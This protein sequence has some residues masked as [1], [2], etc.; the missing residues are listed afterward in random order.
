HAEHYIA[1]WA[2]GSTALSRHNLSYGPYQL[3]LT[4]TLGCQTVYPISLGAHDC[5]RYFDIPNVFTPNGDG[6][7]D[8]LQVRTYCIDRFELQIF[9]RW[10][11]LVYTTQN[12][13]KPWRGN[14]QN[15]PAPEGVY[16]AVLH[17]WLPDGTELVRQ[18]HV[19][20]LR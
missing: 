18:T 7:N 2:D 3:T 10:G 11:Q 12:E 6:V 20:L 9:S 13:D 4:D 1:Q 16:F 19:T 5:C 8:F 14:Y 17:L 15:E